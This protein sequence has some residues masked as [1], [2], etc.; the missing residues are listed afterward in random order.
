MR[1]EGGLEVIY[2]GRPQ[3]GQ[4]PPVA[5]GGGDRPPCRA[6]GLGPLVAREGG[7]RPPCRPLGGR[8]APLF[9][10]GPRCKFKEKK[11]HLGLVALWEGD[12]GVFLKYFK[13]DI[14]F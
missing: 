4:A 12:R 6:R 11:L 14:Y 2:P 5:R 3:G 1:R 7:D 8:Q 10:Q 9:F 13:M